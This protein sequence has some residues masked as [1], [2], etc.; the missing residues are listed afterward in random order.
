MVINSTSNT[1]D[2]YVNIGN[3]T[4][5]AANLIGSNLFWRNGNVNSNA[6]TTLFVL[7]GTSVSVGHSSFLVPNVRIIIYNGFVW[8]L[9]LRIVYGQHSAKH[10]K[11]IPAGSG[12]SLALAAAIDGEASMIGME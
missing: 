10:I 1:W 7:G 5:T 11:A 4:A 3:A 8:Q 6:L 9:R 12:T 2:A